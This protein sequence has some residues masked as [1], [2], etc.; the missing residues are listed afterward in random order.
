[1]GERFPCVYIGKLLSLLAEHFPLPNGL[2]VL[3]SSWPHYSSLHHPLPEPLHRL[4]T[5]GAMVERA[6]IQYA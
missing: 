3:L 2:Y 5:S 6:N 1:M 4:I